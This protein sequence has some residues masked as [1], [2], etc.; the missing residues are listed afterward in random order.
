M[1]QDE[2]GTLAALM[3]RRR[4]ILNPAIARHNG[5]LVKLMG[6]GMLVEFA[7]AVAAVRCAVDLQ[8][9]FAAANRDLPE[10]RRIIL[11]IGVNL[12]DV[13]VEGDDLYGDGINVQRASN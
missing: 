12:G 13:L 11:R 3:A 2:T 5:R 4:D 10:A 6:D 8:G 9:A 1:E 7:S